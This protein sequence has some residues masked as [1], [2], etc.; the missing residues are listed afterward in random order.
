MKKFKLLIF[1]I[2]L[3]DD[4]NEFDESYRWFVIENSCN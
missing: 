4:I 1:F 2:D 3:K